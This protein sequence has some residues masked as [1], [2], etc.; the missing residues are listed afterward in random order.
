MKSKALLV[1]S[2]L[3]CGALL[4]GCDN[5][6]LTEAQIKTIA[7]QAGLFGGVGWIAIDNPD[8]EVKALVIKACSIIR[9]KSSDIE[10][11]KT[12]TEVMYGPIVDFANNEAPEQYRPLTK[13]GALAI[14]GALDVLF[15]S[16]PEWRENQ[17]LATGIINSFCTGA[18]AGLSMA[19]DNP[20]M[21]SAL[22]SAKLRSGLKLSK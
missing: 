22:Q 6:D 9:E 5:S 13:A 19:A 16:N 11:G 2:M 12:Y 7:N 20:V 15:A 21:K 14:L 1:A 4:T 10:A 8:T 18:V 3:I 17:D